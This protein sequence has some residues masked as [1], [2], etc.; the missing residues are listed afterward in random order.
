MF[1]NLIHCA[2]QELY[3][4][5]VT[6][7]KQIL[8]ALVD[9]QIETSGTTQLNNYLKP[10]VLHKQWIVTFVTTDWLQSTCTCP[11]FYKH[12]ICKHMVGL[13]IV[14]NLYDPPPEAKATLFQNKRRPGRPS[15]SSKALVID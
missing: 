14:N 3:S 6:K 12:Y 10:F 15:K 2:I 13:A 11:I 1:A 9:K 8:R 4:L 7:P 5:G